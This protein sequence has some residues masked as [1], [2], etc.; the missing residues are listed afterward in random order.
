MHTHLS[1]IGKSED[2]QHI[3]QRD[4]S[5]LA[6]EFTLFISHQGSVIAQAANCHGLLQCWG[7]VPRRHHIGWIEMN[8]FID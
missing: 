5:R 4:I 7:Y 1:L 3:E 6:H 2:V 8:S